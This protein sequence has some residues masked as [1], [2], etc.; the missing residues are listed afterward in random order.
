MADYVR[1]KTAVSVPLV[2]GRHE[3]LA[4]GQ[5]V[6]AN[7]LDPDFLERMGDDPWLEDLVE[8][9]DEKGLDEWEKAVAESKAQ[10]NLP[11][12]V[13]DGGE[14]ALTSV[15]EGAVNDGEAYEAHGTGE[16]TK[17]EAELGEP[18]SVRAEK[19]KQMVEEQSAKVKAEEKQSGGG[20]SSQSGGASK[21]A[22]K[23]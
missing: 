8:D 21:A 2:D 16:E 4:P 17:G 7:R 15:S 14:R 20:G 22:E 10:P 23:S 1:A 13:G 6:A 3:A 18:R 5:V 12:G 11:V 19:R 9:A